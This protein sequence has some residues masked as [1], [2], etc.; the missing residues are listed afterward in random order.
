[1]QVT[2][3]AARTLDPSLR[4]LSDGEIAQ[5]LLT[6]PEYNMQLGVRELQNCVARFGYTEDS[7]ACYNGGAGALRPSREAQCQ[8]LSVWACPLNG[9]YAGTRRYA[10]S[11][12]STYNNLRVSP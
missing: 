5:R 7:A 3:G 1:M 10:L 8:G 12:M 9:G 4:G 6:D 11:V 2:I